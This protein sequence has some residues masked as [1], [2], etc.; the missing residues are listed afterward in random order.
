MLFMENMIFKLGNEEYRI[1]GSDTFRNNIFIIELCD[2]IRWPQIINQENLEELFI[3]NEAVE[4]KTDKF[5][6]IKNVEIKYEIAKKRDFNYEVICYLI[7]NS[8]EYEIYYKKSRKSIID[9]TI[10]VYGISESSIKRIWCSYLKSGK[11]MQSLIPKT[12]KCGGRG[13]ERVHE[14]GG[15]VVDDKIKRLLKE[16][17]NKY[18]N[19]KKKNNKKMCYELII[20]D[21]LKS[22]PNNNIPSLKQFYYWFSRITKDDKRNEITKRYGDRIYQQ[23]ARAI[24]G[25][26]IQDTLGPGELFQIDSTILDVYLVSK[27]NRNLII[28]RGVLYLVVDVY[29]RMI[30]GM[31]VTIEPFNSFEGAKIAL[32]NTM[33]DKVSYCKKYGISIQ[34]EDWVSAVV[35]TRILSDRGELL[36][37][38][39]ENAIGN[40]GILIQQTN[41]YRGDMKGIVEKSFE[42]L[43]AYIKPFVDGVVENKFNKV[44]RGNVDYRLKANLTLEEITQIVIKYILFYNNN[45]VLNYYESDGINIENSIPKIPSKLWEYGVKVKKGLLRELPEE[46]IRINLLH[47]KEVSVTAKGIRFNKLYYVSKYTLESGFFQ[48]ARIEGSYRVRISYNPNDLSE[49]YYI[50]EDGI[51]YDK[52]TLV[53]YMEHY[54]GMSEEEITKIFEYEDKLNKK[55]SE[56]EIHEKI[57]LFD[58]MEKITGKAKQEQE[59]VKDKALNKTQRLKHIRENLEEERNYFRKNS[60]SDSSD[61]NEEMEVFNQIIADEWGEDYE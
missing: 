50:K 45:H 19:T 38:H 60:S 40:L 48:K 47:N 53:T 17:I 2:Q 1:V 27:M 21:F 41:S 61:I 58:E 7:S 23:T 37:C 35:P 9:R 22:N 55:A 39:I 51:S 57:K 30:V 25:N 28:G 4:V 49:I 24:I 26:S 29:S 33:T 36:S 11:I 5:I 14:R 54:K 18:Y 44:E 52:L 42:R 13:K 43:H 15:F 8:P 31:N 34:K 10:E 16:G 46:I 20:R 12:Y 3:R 59:R 56:K 32:I 6:D